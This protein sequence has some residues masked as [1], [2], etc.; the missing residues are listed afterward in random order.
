MVSLNQYQSP[1]LSFDVQEA[2]SA[3][4]PLKSSEHKGSHSHSKS[5][6]NTIG[7]DS[8]L[9]ESS[10]SFSLLSQDAYPHWFDKK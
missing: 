4:I 10:S 5:T 2:L 3:D 6:F 9:N 1:P 7:V 8:P